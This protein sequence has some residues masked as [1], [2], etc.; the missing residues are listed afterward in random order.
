[1]TRPAYRCQALCPPVAPMR[2]GLGTMAIV[3]VLSQ[4]PVATADPLGQQARIGVAIVQTPD[5]EKLPP[6][7]MQ[8]A[9]SA[10]ASANT[11]PIDARLEA[12]KQLST[13]A[14]PRR[15]IERFASI[16]ADADAGWRAFL[17]VATEFALARLGKARSEAEELLSMPGGIRLYA[18]ISLRLGAVLLHAGRNDESLEA[19]RL[20]RR[21]DPERSLELDEFSPDIIEAVERAT[22]ATLSD[23]WIQITS[24]SDATIE[25]DG[26]LVGKPGRYPVASGHHVVVARAPLR[27]ARGIAIA[28]PPSGTQLTLAL[29]A[30]GELARAKPLAAGDLES[31]ATAVAEVFANYGDLDALFILAAVP[32]LGQRALLGQ[33]C[34]G[35]PMRCTTVAEVA[36]PRP[37]DASA[38]VSRLWRELSRGELRYPLTLPSDPRLLRDTKLAL[39]NR[40]RWCRSPWLWGSV[41]AAVVAAGITTLIVTGERTTTFELDVE[42]GDWRR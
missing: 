10:L 7:L 13:G 30:D 33:K 3:G 23:A 8:Q 25:I 34:A 31:E 12:T 26:Q 36:L 2:N 19:F 15:L 39:D 6:R 32:R 38:A 21:L 35:D 16:A 11:D 42:A 41:S 22:T 27:K 29:E 37:A 40:C 4:A 14:V 18:D 20:A 1:M 28:I 24:D 17:E 5:P 9:L